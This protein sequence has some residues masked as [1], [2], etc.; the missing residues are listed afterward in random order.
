MLQGFGTILGKLLWP[1]TIIIGLFDF[2]KGFRKDEGWD[3][4]PASFFTKIGMGISEALQ[5]LIGLPLDMI[6][7]WYSVDTE[8]IWNRNDHR[9][10]NW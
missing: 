3:G 6:K 9:S 5:G 7:N 4:E 8:E 2:I 1:V 10:R